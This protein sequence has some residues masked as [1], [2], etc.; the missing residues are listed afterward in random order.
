MTEEKVK[1]STCTNNNLIKK[2]TNSL[3]TFIRVKRII[4]IIL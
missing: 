4:S 2:D 1:K 3:I